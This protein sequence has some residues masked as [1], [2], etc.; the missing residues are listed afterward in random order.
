MRS[1]PWIAVVGKASFAMPFAVFVTNTTQVLPF[2][3]VLVMTTGVF[4]SET[5]EACCGHP[6]GLLRRGATPFLGMT[7]F[8]NMPQ[9]NTALY[10]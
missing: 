4:I 6:A 2:I 3:P 8:E 10:I 9:G 7:E 5:G 1:D